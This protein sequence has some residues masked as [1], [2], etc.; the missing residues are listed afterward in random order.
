MVVYRYPPALSA[1]AYDRAE[2]DRLEFVQMPFGSSMLL[3]TTLL[4]AWAQPMGPWLDTALPTLIDEPVEIVGACPKTHLSRG[5]QLQPA[6]ELYTIW[7]PERA[8]GRPEAMEVIAQTAEQLA[9]LLPEADPIVIGDIST[10]FGGELQGHVSHRAG[11]DIDIGVFWEGG[12][13]LKGDHPNPSPDRL[14]LEANWLLIRS[15]L[16]TGLIE[17][18]LLDQRNILRIK[19]YTIESGELTPDE[20][21]RIFPDPE[22]RDRSATGVVHHAPRHLEHFHVRTLCWAGS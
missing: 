6:P 15:L 20:A 2:S 9:W 14:D 18:I 3:T 21:D 4:S 11:V 1:V 10:Q 17:R 8:W 19:A 7:F 13:T 5:V 16:D 22:S 12:Q